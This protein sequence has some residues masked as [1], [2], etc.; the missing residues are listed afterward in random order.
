MRRGGSFYFLFRISISDWN[1]SRVPVGMNFDKIMT[2]IHLTNFNSSGRF[3]AD[4]EG[5]N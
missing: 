5:P 3:V 4:W 2:E 1:A